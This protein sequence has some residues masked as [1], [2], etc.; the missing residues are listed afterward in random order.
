MKRATILGL[1]VFLVMI[2]LNAGA[3]AYG[4]ELSYGDDSN[5]AAGYT[6]SDFDEILGKGYIPIKVTTAGSSGKAEVWQAV[7]LGSTLDCS[8]KILSV[9][10]TTTDTGGSGQGF[11]DSIFGFR[12]TSAKSEF[13]SAT[14]G[15]EVKNSPTVTSSIATGA[16]YDQIALVYGGIFKDTVNIPIIPINILL[17][18]Y[19][20]PQTWN[21]T[22][23]ISFADSK[24][25]T[26]LLE[27]NK[28]YTFEGFL[29][30][31]SWGGVN[32]GENTA[33]FDAFVCIKDIQAPLPATVWLLAG[34]LM[35]LGGLARRR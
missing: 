24:T 8:Q 21:N 27:T 20:N 33:T 14:I 12:I 1:G 26:F 32:P 35:V 4:I 28:D 25:M 10:A 19:P 15:Y 3:W 11:G 18:D 30:V 16:G 2:S 31:E 13:V 23:A 6:E 5:Y 34:G 9:T 7:V 29:A 22:G 17:V